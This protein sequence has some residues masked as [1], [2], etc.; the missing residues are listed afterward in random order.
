MILQ[1]AIG[2]VALGAAAHGAFHPNSSVYGP[3][4]D[5]RVD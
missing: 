3:R 1:I 4:P 5:A 2:V